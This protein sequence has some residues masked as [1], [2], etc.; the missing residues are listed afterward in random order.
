MAVEPANIGPPAATPHSGRS[1]RRDGVTPMRMK[2][3][4]GLRRIALW[5]LMALM[6]AL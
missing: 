3:V 5:T 4:R 1:N 2:D 6:Y